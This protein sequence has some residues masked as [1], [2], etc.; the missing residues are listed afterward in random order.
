VLFELAHINKLDYG[1]L[2]WLENANQF[3]SSLVDRIVPGALPPAQQQ[4]MEQKLGFQDALMIMSEVYGLWAIQSAHPRVNEVLSFAAAES[5]VVIT[6]D[7]TRF[8]ELK[9]RLLNGTH[10]FSCGLAHL[11]GFELVKHAM[12]DATFGRFV[13]DLMKYEIAPCLVGDM[14]S[15]QDT[16][17]F[18]DMVTDRFRNPFLEHKWLSITLNYTHK[19]RMRN[20]PLLLEHYKRNL[21]VP[22]DMALGFAA[23]IL[24]MKSYAGEDG[25]YYGQLNG[26]A[27]HI[28]DDCAAQLHRHWEASNEYAVAKAVLADKT[29]WE[30]NLGDL[31][32]FA[33]GVGDFMRQINDSGVLQVILDNQARRRKLQD[34][35]TQGS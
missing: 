7:I 21:Y 11:A 19:M 23:Y 28:Q 35:E 5:G 18:A 31:P 3:C 24:F 12:E 26:Q 6:E 20:V 25:K 15:E 10:T 9:L 29:L 34:Y 17:A 4:Q 32:G 27:Y 22:D 30:E 13:A 16:V 14:L 8:R 33:Y 1:F 2:D